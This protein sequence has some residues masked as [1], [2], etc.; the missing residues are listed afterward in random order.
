MTNLA[1]ETL[2]EVSRWQREAAPQPVAL[3]TSA[4]PPP[5]STTAAASPTDHSTQSMMG[6]CAEPRA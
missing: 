4:Y 5:S 2:V 6:E 3:R 1:I